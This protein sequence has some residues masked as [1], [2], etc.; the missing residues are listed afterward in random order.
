MNKQIENLYVSSSVACKPYVT[1]CINNSDFFNTPDWQNVLGSL[2]A[3]ANYHWSDA[4]VDGFATSTFRRG[5]FSIAYV[6]FPDGKQTISSAINSE[7]MLEDVVRSCLTLGV[8]GVRISGL[9]K[10]D[11]CLKRY[12]CE[13]VIDSEIECLALWKPEDRSSSI[14]RNIR[15]SKKSGVEITCVVQPEKAESMYSLYLETI[16]RHHGVARYSLKY[17]EVL[18]KL[19]AKKK[20]TLRIYSAYFSGELIAYTVTANHQ[21]SCVYLHGAQKLSHQNMRAMDALFGA[22]ISE[23]KASRLKKFSFQGSPM[24]QVGLIKYKEKWGAV[25]TPKST[26]TAFGAGIA[27]MALRFALKAK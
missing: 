16:Q 6:G 25:S 9:P 23:A 14:H 12:Q 26:V 10:D 21:T 5:P 8:T 4:L 13:D 20:S 18:L 2:G 11:L 24:Q 27:P 3:S 19:A 7:V 1:Q 17:F 15:K 22:M